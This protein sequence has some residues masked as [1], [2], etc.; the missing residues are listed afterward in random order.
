M[1]PSTTG[2]RHLGERIARV[3]DLMKDLVAGKCVGTQSNSDGGLVR[4]AHSLNSTPSSKPPWAPL[5][6]AKVLL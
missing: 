3:E 5:T 1:A 4:H 2:N 6:P